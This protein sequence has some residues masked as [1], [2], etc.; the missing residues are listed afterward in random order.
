MNM[1]NFNF[2]RKKNAGKSR[3]V[4]DFPARVLQSSQIWRKGEGGAKKGT[5]RRG[6]RGGVRWGDDVK[7]SETG[8]E[9]NKYIS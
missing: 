9:L 6:D 1:N 8:G 4:F 5:G 7:K 2:H 3:P